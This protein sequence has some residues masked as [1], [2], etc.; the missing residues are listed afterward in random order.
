MMGGEDCSALTGR[1]E[2]LKLEALGI[3][4]F[5][6]RAQAQ[7]RQELM[8]RRLSQ[9][10]R[11]GT[12][13]GLEDCCAKH[14]AMEPCRDGCHFAARRLRLQLLPQ[15]FTLLD[16]HGGLL[17]SVTMVHPG[18]AASDDAGPAA[19]PMQAAKQW[20]R[21]RLRAVNGLVSVGSWE[22][23]LN[24]ELDGTRHWAGQIHLVTGGASTAELKQALSVSRKHV[25]AHAKPLKVQEVDNLGRQL[26]YAVKR[27]AEQRVAYIDGQGRKNRRHLPLKA[28][29]QARFD[30]WLCDLTVGERLFLVGCHRH[31]SKLLAH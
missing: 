29:D 31:G 9:T 15:A 2:R 12:L 21:R 25:A 3:P 7:K 27:F 18:W 19:C 24:L 16:G 11:N 14:C 13:G 30:A 10:A 8:L 22:V 23:C 17:K 20:V 6:T 26:G 1:Q 5:E 4:D 28:A